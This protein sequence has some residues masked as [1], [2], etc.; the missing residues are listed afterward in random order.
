MTEC[1]RVSYVLVL[2]QSYSSLVHL[3]VLEAVAAFHVVDHAFGCFLCLLRP[4][5]RSQ[6]MHIK[7]TQ[8]RTVVTVRSSYKTWYY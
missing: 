8:T 4:V 6:G 5:T 2:S 7:H 1:C 3:A